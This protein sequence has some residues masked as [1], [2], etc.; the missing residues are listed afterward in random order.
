MQYWVTGHAEE[1][2]LWREVSQEQLKALLRNRYRK[3]VHNTHGANYR[4]K[5]SGSNYELQIGVTDAVN[6]VVK[7]KTVIFKGQPDPRTPRPSPKPGFWLK[8]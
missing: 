7:I 1:H 5:V 3:V 2:M 4:A 6:G 8:F